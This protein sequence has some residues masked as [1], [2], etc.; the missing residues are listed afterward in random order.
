M[1]WNGRPWSGRW[2]ERLFRGQHYRPMVGVRGRRTIVVPDAGGVVLWSMWPGREAADSLKCSRPRGRLPVKGRGGG[3]RGRYDGGRVSGV[4]QVLWPADRRRRH[5]RRANMRR[6]WRNGA[7]GRRADRCPP[8]PRWLR[9]RRPRRPPTQ[10]TGQRRTVFGRRRL[11]AGHATSSGW[12]PTADDDRKPCR[13]HVL[14]HFKR[15]LHYNIFIAGNRRE[16][17]VFAYSHILCTYI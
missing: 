11:S 14:N 16:Q 13:Q 17:R 15:V 7:H 6:R 10:A 9:L 8:G 2:L 12:G 3:G 4:Y 5:K 1:F